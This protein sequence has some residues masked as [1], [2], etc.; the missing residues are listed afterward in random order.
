MNITQFFKNTLH[1]RL[2]DP[3][4]S[5]GAIDPH[6]R[7]FFRLRQ[8]QIHPDAT[9]EKVEIYQKNPTVHSAGYNE[10][11]KHLEAIKGGAQAF[12]IVRTARKT[13]DGGRK[14]VDFNNS[15]LLRLGASFSED[16]RCIYAHIASRIP[17]SELTKLKI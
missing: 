16:S 14:T 7:I 1:A 12:G 17:I 4:W 3:V 10:R 8:D 13:P 15:L 11:R 2:T 5:W 9:G 6:N